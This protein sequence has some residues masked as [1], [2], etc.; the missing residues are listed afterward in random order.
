FIRFTYWY[1]PNA[2]RIRNRTTDDE[3]SRFWS[4]NNIDFFFISVTNNFVH[5]RAKCVAVCHYWSNIFK[6]NTFVRPVFWCCNMFFKFHFY[7]LLLVLYFLQ[8]FFL[9]S[10]LCT[11]CFFLY[12]FIS[13][14]KS[15]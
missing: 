10:F 1:E 7:L 11:F 4:Y 9:S 8:Y 5:C 3:T 2:K 15:L 6:F 13:S 12:S 14:F